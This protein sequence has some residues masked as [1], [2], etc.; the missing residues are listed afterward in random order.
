MRSRGAPAPYSTRREAVTVL[1]SVA[2]RS[3]SL[4]SSSLRTTDGK[5]VGEEETETLLLFTLGI[6]LALHS[7]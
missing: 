5:T 7:N 1:P 2:L 4:R 3:P 6:F